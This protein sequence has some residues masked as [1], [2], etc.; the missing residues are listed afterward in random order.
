MDEIFDAAPLHSLTTAGRP[1]AAKLIV[2]V[3]VAQ[4]ADAA[5]GV[6]LIWR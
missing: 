5:D 2:C 4:K 3:Y 1:V 6:L